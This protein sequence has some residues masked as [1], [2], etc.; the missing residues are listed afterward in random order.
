ME[1]GE[2]GVGWRVG[3]GGHLHEV[4]K[5]GEV[6]YNFK[7]F[8]NKGRQAQAKKP[9][10]GLTR[11]GIFTLNAAALALLGKPEYIVYLF[12]PEARVIGLRPASANEAGAYKVTTTMR[13]RGRYPYYT[14]CAVA[15]CNRYNIEHGKP[16]HFT[17]EMVDGVMTLKERRDHV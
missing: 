12:D 15:F 2:G 11:Q 9:R 6:N 3:G 10:V 7:E 14:I 8:V 17:P 16:R 13:N 5:E 1:E 4:R